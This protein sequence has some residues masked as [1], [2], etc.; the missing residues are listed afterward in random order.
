MTRNANR[1]L[2]ALLAGVTAVV[3]VMLVLGL[4]GA[5]IGSTPGGAVERTQAAAEESFLDDLGDD[6]PGLWDM[7]YADGVD[8]DTALVNLGHRA[9]TAAGEIS[10]ASPYV[11]PWTSV[12]RIM[13]D[14]GFSQRDALALTTH[15]Q[16][17][18]CPAG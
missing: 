6:A 15:A 18:L 17:N 1:V 11:S 2:L 4:S 10:A 5:A 3:T 16:H 7:P 12:T 14:S 8:P 9:C 13:S